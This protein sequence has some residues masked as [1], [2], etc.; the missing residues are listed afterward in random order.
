MTGLK[1][2]WDGPWR[3]RALAARRLAGW[4]EKSQGFAEG[5]FWAIFL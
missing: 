2:M 3:A 4:R 5:T 1:S